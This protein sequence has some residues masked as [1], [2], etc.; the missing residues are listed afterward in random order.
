V[1]TGNASLATKSQAN[2]AQFND[3]DGATNN[4][5]GAAKDLVKNGGKLNSPQL[6]AAIAD[7]KSTAG[8]WAQGQFATSGLTPQER[9]Y[10]V[11]VKSYKEN[12]QSLRKSAGGSVSDAQVDRLMSMAPG[13]A[14]PDLDYLLRQTGQIRQMRARLAAGVSTA[15]GGIKVAGRGNRNNMQP[16]TQGGKAGDPL[17]V[18]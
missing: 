5:E 9:N 2:A 14:T 12:L 17:G 4:I 13:S 3:I 15:H 10:V 11:Q 1:G 18:R 16:P 8:Q 6:V 7:P